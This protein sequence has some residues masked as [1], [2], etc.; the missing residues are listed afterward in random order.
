MD[1]EIPNDRNLKPSEQSSLTSGERFEI[2]TTHGAPSCEVCGRR[3]KSLRATVI[4]Y[5]FSFLVITMRRSWVGVYCWRH[6]LQR[7]LAA[8]FISSLLGWWGIPWGLIHTPITL[9]KLAKGGELPEEENVELLARVAVHKLNT[10]E[11]GEAIQIF[12]EAL[13]IKEDERTRNSL[14]ELQAKYP[15]SYELK[16]SRAPLWYILSLV[17]ASFIGM[18]IGLLDFLTVFVLGWILG[19]ETHILLAIL[20]WAPLVAMIFIGALLF[21]E[22]LR[23]VL[24]RTGTDHLLIG[25]LFAIGAGGLV[26]YG[27][28]QG[29][30]IGDYL[31]AIVSGL[32][33]DSAGDFLLTT[34][35]V[36]S[37]GG[38]W[39]VLDVFES[40]LPGDWIYLVLWGF[41]GALYFWLAFRSA[42]ESVHWRVRLELLQ[43]DL[44]MEE[45]RS[46]L[47]IWG[48]LGGY[49]LFLLIGF[50]IF[51]GRGRLLRGGP[52]LVAYIEQGDEFSLAG[53]YEQAE[54]VYRQAIS[55][56]PSQPGPHESL[57]WVLYSMGDMEQ[58]TAEFEQ[59][60]ELDPTWA[61]P[62]L[63]IGYIHFN[64]GELAAAEQAF[65]T[66]LQ[67]A[68]EPTLAGQAYYGLGMLSHRAD[69]LET[70]VAYYGQAVREDWQLAMAHMDMAIAYY[71]MSDF[72]RAIE[73]ANDLIAIAPDWGAP[74]ALLALAHY[75]L[76]S[77]EVF[78]RELDWAKES[79]S[80]D[81]YSQLLVS[82]VY[83][84]LEEYDAAREVLLSANLL[85]PEEPQI[86]LLLAKL[87][88]LEGDFQGAQER[89]DRQLENNPALVDALLARA[90]IF[91]EMQDLAQAESALDRALILEPEHWE[92]RSLRSF[93]Y[94]HQGRIEE[95]YA[96]ADAAIRAYA[97]EGS[98]Y[99]HRAF[100]ARARGDIEGAFTDAQQ[101]IMLNPKLDIAHFILGVVYFDRGESEQGAAS[102]RTFLELARD[103]AYVRDYVQQA[104]AV[105]AQ[106]P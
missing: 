14:L 59:A 99:V 4:P 82:E 29:Y 39:F 95:A 33:F 42:Q 46:L 55:V 23:F 2:P 28:P 53:D 5:L 75:Q 27:L 80:I 49:A 17:T 64:K 65:Q 40:G 106:L 19:S 81:L 83:W 102:L 94:F 24:E 98:C 20:S 35:A 74:H 51:A 73:H 43:G 69:D 18:G 48:A 13:R 57:A 63:G 9:L 105:L 101:A 61:D 104:Q 3:D 21:N 62:Y 54:T 97:F 34:G 93:V 25:M 6:R 26:W 56:A 44:R 100:A 16:E 8:G 22:L 90:W 85:Y 7:L 12:Q 36:I 78:T 68:D 66:A 37:Q 89:I 92:A 70:A 10:G 30:L 79:G 31:S 47:P 96:E 103:R 50:S 52:D 76:N 32:S 86:P 88:A 11:P 45:P 60:M 58:A 71:A 91:I 15:L 77:T 1:G 87:S 72:P 38:I 41:A 84:I 67:L